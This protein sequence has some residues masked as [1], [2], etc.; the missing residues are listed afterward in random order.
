MP[1]RNHG[2]L[3]MLTT[4]SSTG[5]TTT[6]PEHGDH[7]HVVWPGRV[8]IRRDRRVPQQT[9][10]FSTQ[11]VRSSRLP[12]LS[13]GYYYTATVFFPH[14]EQRPPRVFPQVLRYL[15]LNTSP[16][17]VGGDPD[18]IGYSL[19]HVKSLAHK[20]VWLSGSVVPYILTELFKWHFSAS[21]T[22]VDPMPS[23][24]NDKS[25]ASQARSHPAF[26][27]SSQ[28]RAKASSSGSSVARRDSSNTISHRG[29]TLRSA[30]PSRAL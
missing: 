6:K 23:S 20:F 21:T 17:D 2:Q 10:S 11:L 4:A 13:N 12:E 16:F 9:S 18:R 30:S 19:S 3:P 5:Q 29:R 14:T 27:I 22:C 24:N 8:K 25:Y 28:N 15:A 26:M 1:N 7:G